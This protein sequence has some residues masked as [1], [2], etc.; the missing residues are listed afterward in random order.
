MRP[1]H[2]LPLA[3]RAPSQPLPP[4]RTAKPAAE[5]SAPATDRL[6]TQRDVARLLGVTIQ[7]LAKWR[8]TGKGPACVPLARNVARYNADDIKSYIEELRASASTPTQV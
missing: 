4:A 2:T 3:N 6:L 5:E 8:R 1:N 7:T